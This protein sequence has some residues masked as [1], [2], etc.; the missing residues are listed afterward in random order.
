MLLNCMD[1]K[2]VQ[3]KDEKKHA[4]ASKELNETGWNGVHKPPVLVLLVDPIQQL[5]TF[6]ASARLL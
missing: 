1:R 3:D 6:F 4:F 5:T 2:G